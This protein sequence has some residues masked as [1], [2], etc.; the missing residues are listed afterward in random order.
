MWHRHLACELTISH[1][2]E[3]C[4]TFLIA[5]DREFFDLQKRNFAMRGRDCQV[6]AE[7]APQNEL[8]RDPGL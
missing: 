4:A 1:G 3:G 8:P 2:P 6:A 7:T 5:H